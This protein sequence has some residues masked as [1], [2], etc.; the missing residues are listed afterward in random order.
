MERRGDFR[1]V[2]AGGG[3][4]GLSLASMLQLHDIDY[5]LLELNPDTAPQ[6]DANIS[7]LP[8]GNRI[9]DQLGLYHQLLALG[10]SVDLLHFRGEAGEMIRE[11]RGLKRS[12]QER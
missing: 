8:H 12:M 1:V 9:L 2:I 10:T 6:L 5:V 11:V 7:L 3:I 4:T